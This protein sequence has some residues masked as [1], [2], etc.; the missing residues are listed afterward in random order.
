MLSFENRIV[1]G[2]TAGQ[3]GTIAAMQMKSDSLMKM[4]PIA[5]QGDYKSIL[6]YSALLYPNQ[7]SQIKLV[8]I[9]RE[10]FTNNLII[11]YYVKG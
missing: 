11:V 6:R 2:V 3:L 8:K 1:R 7:K 9:G 5:K 10:D 4:H